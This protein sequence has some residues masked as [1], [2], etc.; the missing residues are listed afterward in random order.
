MVHTEETK[1]KIGDAHRGE[2]GAFYGKEFSAEHKRH[3]SESL[4]GTKHSEESRKRRSESI[5]GDK[6][7]MYGKEVSEETRKR[8][9]RANMGRL[10]GEKTPSSKLTWG[11]AREIR[12]L[13]KESN[14]THKELAS[15]FG[16]TRSTV[17]LIVRNKTWKEEYDPENQIR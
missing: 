7:P 5:R 15:M 16:V 6:N 10:A 2:K 12:R 11:Q 17:S 13:F 14:I 4:K 9:S 8:I 3:I 1:K